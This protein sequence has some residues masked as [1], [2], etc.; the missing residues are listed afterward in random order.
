VAGPAVLQDFWE[1]D[2]IADI[3]NSKANFISGRKDIDRGFFVINNSAYLGMGNDT[4]KTS[5]YNDFWQYNTTTDSWTQIADF[6]GRG[7]HGAVG[8]S[9]CTNGYLGL[10]Q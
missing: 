9:I 1:Y 3:W 4:N 10:G 7:R 6:P 5:V 8:F 2:P